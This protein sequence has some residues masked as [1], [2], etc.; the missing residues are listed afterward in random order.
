VF[1]LFGGPQYSDGQQRNARIREI[2]P[3]DKHFFP[4]RRC[5]LVTFGVENVMLVG[6]RSGAEVLPLWCASG[7]KSDVAPCRKCATSRLMH[8]SNEL[9][10]LSTRLACPLRQ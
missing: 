3:Y 2:V 4:L 7:L 8:R 1:P 9:L 6:R 10:I 5:K